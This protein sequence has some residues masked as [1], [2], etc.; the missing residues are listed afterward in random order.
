[1]RDNVSGKKSGAQSRG[2]G[3][4]YAGAGCP[5]FASNLC[6]ANNTIPLSTIGKVKYLGFLSHDTPA[7]N[8]FLPEVIKRPND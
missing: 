6:D 1:M 2:G 7:L 4:N 3:D 5:G 8:R